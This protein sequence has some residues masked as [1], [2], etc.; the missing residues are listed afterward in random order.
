MLPVLGYMNA[1]N[2]TRQSRPD[3]RLTMNPSKA[4]PSMHSTQASAMLVN[5]AWSSRVR[6]KVDSTSA[7]VPTVITSRAMNSVG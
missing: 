1:G 6:L 2:S 3:S 4:M 5:A 7:G